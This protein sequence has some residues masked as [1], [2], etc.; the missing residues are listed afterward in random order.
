MI[1]PFLCFFSFCFSKLN[2]ESTEPKICSTEVSTYTYLE[3]WVLRIS[4]TWLA[5]VVTWLLNCSVAGVSSGHW[6]NVCY[7]D[8]LSIIENSFG[9]AVGFCV[10]ST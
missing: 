9:S 6:R 5:I 3:S 8:M 1:A 10:W 2:L 4:S 7:V